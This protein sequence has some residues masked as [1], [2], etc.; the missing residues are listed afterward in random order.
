MVGAGLTLPPLSEKT[1]S[2]LKETLFP[3]A[4]VANPIDVLATGTAEHYRACLDAMMADDNFDCV[5]VN[6]VTP[7]FVDN[8][9]IAREIVA[10]N[11]QKIKP[12]VCNLM[13]NRQEWTEVVP[14]TSF[15]TQPVLI[16]GIQTVYFAVA[17]GKKKPHAFKRAS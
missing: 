10:V 3:E 5:Y 12:M 2:V 7:F 9:S 4:S 8:E 14:Q 1:E 13:T 15:G 17:V 6:F 11:D 16:Q